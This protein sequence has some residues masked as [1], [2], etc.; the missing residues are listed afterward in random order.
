MRRAKIVCTM[1]PAVESAEKVRELIDAGMNMARLNLSHGGYPEHQ[2]RLDQVRL[3][4]KE[5]GVPVAILV[6]LQGPI[7][8]K[9]ISYTTTTI[10]VQAK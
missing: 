10:C 5:A 6:D 2:A 8:E 9:I 7:W 3:A 1:G 4:S